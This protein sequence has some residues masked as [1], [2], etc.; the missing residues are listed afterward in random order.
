MPAR[1]VVNYT[2]MRIEALVP[3]ILAT[4]FV[5]L[6]VIAGAVAQGLAESSGA[7]LG[8][9]GWEAIR[10]GQITEASRLF[11]DAIAE[12]AHDATLFL[13][14]G[15]AAHL[16]RQEM[17]AR[18]ALQEA[19]R[20]NPKLTAAAL[21]LGDITYRMGDL[22]TAVRTY[23]AALEIEPNNAQIQGRLESW[24][25]EAALHGG[26]Q[27]TLS[28]HFTVL[29][30]GPAEQRLAAAAVDALEAAYWRI[31]TTL[32]A[33]PPTVITVV[34]Y[35]DEQ[36]RDITRSPAWAGGVFD[37]K[38]RV[39]MRGALNDPRQLE[40]VLAHEFTH[41]LIKS[42]APHGVP[43][44]V[45]EGLAVVFEMGDLKWAERLARRAPSLVPLPRLHDGFLSL[46]ADQVPLAYAESALAVQMLIERGG[47]PTLTALLQDL[48]EGQE[49][50]QAFERRVFLSYPEFLILW[51]RRIRE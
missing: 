48:A 7:A 33:Y 29:F 27:R 34:L 2:A 26:F 12:N 18:T 8:R 39:P 41:A 17:E 23:E 21:L 49:F 25:K 9:Q 40:K 37:G 13:G 47:I 43:T 30:E 20:L 10:A 11:H 50:T 3:R 14:A 31:G 16:Q 15:L 1:Q 51:A 32:L 42:L 38:I 28:P 5:L 36:F 6:W 35:T 44:W 4:G 19:V 46:P 45:D 22:E 24:R